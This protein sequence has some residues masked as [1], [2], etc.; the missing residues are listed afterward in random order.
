[1]SKVSLNNIAALSSWT[2]AGASIDANS[3]VIQ[4][5]IDNTL[6][7]D[8]T[9]P[10]QMMHDLDMNSFR[11]LNAGNIELSD[12]TLPYIDPVAD[13]NASGSAQIATGSIVAGSPILILNDVSDF[14]VGHGICIFGIGAMPS[15]QSPTNPSV[16]PTGTTGS[17]TYV[18]SIAPLDA[19]GGVGKAINT[20]S[21]STGNSVLSQTQYVN[22]NAISWSAPS[23]GP[24]PKAYAIYGDGGLG[25]QLSLIGVTT[26]TTFND[27]GDIGWSRVTPYWV[28]LTPPATLIP[29]ALITTVV[30]G[31]GT[32]TLT[33][34]NSAINTGL[35]VTAIHDDTIALTAAFNAGMTKKMPVKIASG[36]YIVSSLIFITMSGDIEVYADRGAILKTGPI[37]SSPIVIFEDT[38]ARDRYGLTWK[39]GTFDNSWGLFVVAQ[40]SNSCISATRLIRLLVEGAFF[41]G[42]NTYTRAGISND[43]GIQFSDCKDVTIVGNFFKGMG[44]LGI[45]NGGGGLIG[46]DDGGGDHSI[47]GNHFENC[48]GACSYK[49]EGPRLI[50][51]NNTIR[52]CYS[53]FSTLETGSGSGTIQGGREVIVANNTFASLET[54]A[55]RLDN[56]DYGQIIGNKITDFGYLPDGLTVSGIPAAI[57]NL[58]SSNLRISNNIIALDLWSQLGVTA[59]AFAQRGSGYNIADTITVTGGAV[60]TVDTV[61]GSGRIITAHVS[62]P[63]VYVAPTPSNPVSQISTSGLGTGAQFNLT[64]GGNGSTSHQA[65]SI[66]GYT[67]N[68]ITYLPNRTTITDNDFININTAIIENGSQGTPGPTH[69]LDNTFTN[70]THFLTAVNTSSF[71]MFSDTG[72]GSY[73]QFYGNAESNRF[74]NGNMITQRLRTFKHNAGVVDINGFLTTLAFG[75]VTANSTSDLDVL[76]S[77]ATA[78]TIAT[79]G[80]GYV[81]GDTIALAGGTSTQPT[82]INVVT[83]DTAGSILTATINTAGFYSV[84]PSNPVSQ[85][86]TTGIGTGATFTMTYA[87]GTSGIVA[88]SYFAECTPVLATGW[89]AGISYQCRC[90]TNKITVRAINNTTSDIV[91]PSG[92]Y[93]LYIRQLG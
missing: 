59:L 13:Y 22:Y 17:T 30:S 80:S 76:F 11:I 41:T 38:T 71:S 49:R 56:S 4:K 60:I 84:A 93:N 40:D 87:G 66:S 18:Y 27:I 24:T 7:R 12:A 45:Y 36:T 15:V 74:F 37:L 47:I 42:A 54:T 77:Q 26:G 78:V 92:S 10:N 14:E 81:A 21:T 64:F 8:G 1:M 19:N 20:F 65:I 44:D 69:A 58:G 86:S 43:S 90:D 73:R 91:L 2:S 25:G 63:G 62:T 55:V 82:V 88:S 52:N 57:R 79:P 67:L 50:F 31:T 23:S 28:P 32:N 6:S 75:T 34:S 3:S 61:D 33:L 85:A 68:S 16:T 9:S 72:T 70:V 39:G 5:A 89:P 51:A 46:T 35:N 83:V 53:G 48:I 29:Q